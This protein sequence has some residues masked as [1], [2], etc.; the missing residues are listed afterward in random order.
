MSAIRPDK[1]WPDP[2]RIIVATFEPMPGVPL[3]VQAAS[4]TNGKW[5]VLLRNGEATLF[6]TY[7]RDKCEA[8]ESAERLSKAVLRVGVLAVGSIPEP[9]AGASSLPI[10]RTVVTTNPP[11]AKA[12]GTHKRPAGAKR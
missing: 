12:N 11:A 2:Q 10:V 1:P 4:T 3:C 8:V 7:C 9:E 6:L 5:L